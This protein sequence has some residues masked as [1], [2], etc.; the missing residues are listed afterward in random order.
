MS[1][2]TAR[3]WYGERAGWIAA[4]L[5]TLTGVFTFYE[6][7][8]LQSSLDTIL[9]AAALWCLADAFRLKAEATR[10]R[11]VAS[12]FSR[13]IL[14]CGIIFGLQTLNR[15]NV[16]VAVVGMLAVLVLVRQARTAALV[17]A[18]VLV[19]LVARPHP[20]RDRVAP[21]RVVVLTGGLNFFIGNQRRGHRAIHAVPERARQHRRA[22]GRHAE[23]GGK[24]GR[25]RAD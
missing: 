22:V 7:L 11:R 1:S 19:A 2:W 16:L 8:I 6:A 5:A 3:T 4:V 24:G 15:P 12:G 9:T 17:V 18:G 25:A 13:K 21:V 20:K 10:D 23:G 14:L